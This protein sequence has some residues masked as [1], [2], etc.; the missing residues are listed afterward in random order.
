MGTEIW[1]LV[2]CSVVR[3]A[4]TYRTDPQGVFSQLKWQDEYKYI[5]YLNLSYPIVTAAV[6]SFY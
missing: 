4:G 3:E 2:Y 5:L 6:E 1:V